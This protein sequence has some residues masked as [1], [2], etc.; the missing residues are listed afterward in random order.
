MDYLKSGGEVSINTEVKGIEKINN[1]WAVKT[2]KGN[3]FAEQVIVAA[4]KWSD[5]INFKDN[6]K[7][8]FKKTISPLMIT[9]PK[10]ANNNFVRMSPFVDRTI[11]HLVHTSNENEY[12]VIGNG[13]YLDSSST[14]KDRLMLEKK[15]YKEASKVFPKL[16]NIKLSK[17]YWGTKTELIKDNASRNY[18]F[19]I[20]EE[21]AGLWFVIPGKFSL[22]FSLA[23][24]FHRQI[25]RKSPRIN[26]QNSNE[27]IDSKII[28]ETFKLVPEM[29]HSRLVNKE[30]N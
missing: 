1:T 19:S 28:Q 20:N 5:E 10:V 26:M 8:I 17:I 27:A 15:F 24:E 23:I 29:L 4:G 12:S 30:I 2:S 21:K 18:Q 16:N 13:M 7:N 6:K 11:N 22:I 14:E 9:F 3:Y 25:K